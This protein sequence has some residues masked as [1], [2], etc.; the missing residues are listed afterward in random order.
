MKNTDLLIGEL[1]HKQGSISQSNSAS[2]QKVENQL[3]KDAL[4]SI[5]KK[6]KDIENSDKIELNTLHEYSNA[7]IN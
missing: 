3:R 7:L 4:E 5:R 2:R 1:I 6:I